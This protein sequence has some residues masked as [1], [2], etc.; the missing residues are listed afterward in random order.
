MQGVTRVVLGIAT[1]LIVGPLY[2]VVSDAL[3]LSIL[4]EMS[5]LGLIGLVL[6]SIAIKPGSSS[7]DQ[8]VQN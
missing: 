6:W 3:G 7:Q 1:G 2:C 8:N 4:T 5:L